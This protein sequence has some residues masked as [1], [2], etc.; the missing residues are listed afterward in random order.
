MSFG[1]LLDKYIKEIGCNAKDLSD[2]SGISASVISRYRTG[3]RLPAADSEIVKKL[4][5][6]IASLSNTDRDR[7]YNQLI[8]SLTAKLSM[9]KQAFYKVDSIVE[10]LGIKQSCIAKAFN[11]DASFIS[12]V[13]SGQRFPSDIEGFLHDISDY[14]AG[15]V[16]DENKLDIVKDT[17]AAFPDEEVN[18][19]TLSTILFNWFIM[20][21]T[22]TISF[23]SKMDSF[24]MNEFLSS[25]HFDDITFPVSYQP[26][27]SR[28]YQGIEEMKI[29]ELDF[30]NSTVMSR[31]LEDVYIYSDMSM[32]DMADNNFTKKYMVGLALMIKKG[33]HIHIIHTLNRPID[34]IFIGLLAW[35]PIYMT[36]QVT[37]YYFDDFNDN[38]FTHLNY[39]SGT[40]AL[41]GSGLT[42]L[43]DH[44]MYYIT[45]N[46]D[47]L[48]YF[49]R[50]SIDMIK[51]AKPLMETY[52]ATDQAVFR[53]NMVKTFEASSTISHILTMPPIG[54]M[55]KEL[56]G[57]MLDNYC[58]SPDYKGPKKESLFDEISDAIDR[59]RRFLEK[60]SNECVIINNFH[61]IPEKIFNEAPVYLSLG[62]S[63]MDYSI[64]YTYELY[65]E[66]VSLTKKFAKDNHYYKFTSA[67]KQV[68]KKIHI[69]FGTYKKDDKDYER[70]ITSQVPDENYD[71]VLISKSIS[72]NIHFFI[73]HPAIVK[74][75]SRISI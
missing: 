48:K 14:I 40:V 1:E 63:F 33:L 56:L 11:Y 45:R 35:V 55:S 70:I 9:A 72:P 4:A 60:T 8:D 27:F 73:E 54:T 65:K 57:K 20:D 23:L 21:E 17:I 62:F 6:G 29:G 52:K 2:A 53:K 74:A 69:I 58:S 31:S 22:P 42:G 24:N 43:R 64:P 36:G 68:F 3:E 30:V 38:I 39:T 15:Y 47:E 10:S 13:L 37:P 7:I 12:R 59:E 61:E 50:R 34:E 46:K 71:W 67:G 25:M 16:L 5:D 44:G 18:K 28:V 32:N 75:L 19:I 49:R 51:K 41:Y 66:H 26:P